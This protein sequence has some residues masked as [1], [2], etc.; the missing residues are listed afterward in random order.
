M[1]SDPILCAGLAAALRQHDGFEVFVHGT[2]EFPGIDVPIDVVIAD[3]ST[4]MRMR[5]RPARHALGLPADLRV[6]VLTSNDREV[7]IRRAIE[8]GVHGYLLIGGPLNELVD[9]VKTVA[10]GMRYMSLSVAQRMADSLTR[11]SLTSREVEVLALVATG[12]QNKVIA[13]RLNIELGTVKSHVSAIMTKLGASSRT[14]AA[15]IA[16]SRG[17]IEE[18]VDAEYS[19]PRARAMEPRMQFA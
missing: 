18:H 4:A 16:A 1:H 2:D 14:E 15:T 19:R 7:D 3:Y 12:Q 13:R 17:L 10:S 6:L 8:A 9:A 11:T 5:D